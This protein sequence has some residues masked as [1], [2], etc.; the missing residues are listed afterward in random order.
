MGFIESI[1][2]NDTVSECVC[3]CVCV[4][5]SGVFIFKALHSMY[6]VAASKGCRP[7]LPMD[8]TLDLLKPNEKE[9]VEAAIKKVWV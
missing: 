5:M 8:S 6:S 4:C 3:V 2:G 9:A 7:P 1:P